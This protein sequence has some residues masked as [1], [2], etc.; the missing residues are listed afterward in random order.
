MKKFLPFSNKSLIIKNLDIFNFINYNVY[1]K[2]E[3]MKIK[4]GDEHGMCVL[5][6][7]KKCNNCGECDR[8]DLDPTKICD[9]CGA[10]ISEYNTNEK[11]F[12]ENSD[13]D[14]MSKKIKLITD[15]IKHDDLPSEFQKFS[16]SQLGQ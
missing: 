4:H 6:D 1:I 8:C 2:G 12:V 3:F 14:E 13:Y 10:C 5:E 16:A 9:N 7:D 11:G 15:S